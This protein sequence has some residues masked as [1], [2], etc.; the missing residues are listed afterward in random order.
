MGRFGT[1][2]FGY[3]KVLLFEVLLFEVLL[4]EVLL[5][6]V[7]AGFLSNLLYVVLRQ[8]F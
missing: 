4:F 3:F 6:E 2:F 7:I 8:C 5:F 1:P